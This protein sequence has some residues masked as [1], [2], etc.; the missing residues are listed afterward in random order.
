MHPASPIS[1]KASE[2]EVILAKNCMISFIQ[3]NNV[4]GV[5][6]VSSSHQ[7]TPRQLQR[8]SRCYLIEV[9]GN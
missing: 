6:Q 8:S 4:M 5:V 9:N 3:R 7:P 1:P 2:I